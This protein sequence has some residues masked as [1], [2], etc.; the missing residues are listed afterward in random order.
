M[1]GLQEYWA[2]KGLKLWLG[3]AD[4]IRGHAKRSVQKL[5]FS[6]TECSLK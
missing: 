4:H 3:M 5:N 2:N 6:E 1:A